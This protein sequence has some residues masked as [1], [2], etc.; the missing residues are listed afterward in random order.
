MIKVVAYIETLGTENFKEFLNTQFNYDMLNNV[1][2][3]WTL[4]SNSN[5]EF[6]NDDKIIVKFEKTYYTLKISDIEYELP[7]PNTINDFINDMLR[8][9][10]SLYWSD[11][12]EEQFEP[13]DFLSQSEIVNY[14]KNLLRV[15]DKEHELI[16]E[17]KK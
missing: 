10:V 1:F 5:D 3:N 9:N 14:Y 12:I 16:T 8:F 7:F 15:L 6:I 2:K 11:W 17:T 13:K 4:V